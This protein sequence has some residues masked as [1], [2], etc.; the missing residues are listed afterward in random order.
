[1]SLNPKS[2]YASVEKLRGEV[3]NYLEGRTTLAENAGPMK[4]A[5]LFYQRNKVICLLVSFF[6]FSLI[7]FIVVQFNFARTK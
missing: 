6:L 2:R 1:M 3:A 4:E 7:A 5:L